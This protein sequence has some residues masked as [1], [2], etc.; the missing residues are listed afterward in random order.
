MNQG[1]AVGEIELALAFE[2]AERLRAEGLKQG[3]DLVAHLVG[4]GGRTQRRL[5]ESIN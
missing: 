1:T 4:S 3:F 2:C 5:E